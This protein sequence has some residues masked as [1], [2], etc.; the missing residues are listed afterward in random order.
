MGLI[1]LLLALSVV[2][3][4]VGGVGGSVLVGGDVAVQGFFVISGFYMALVLTEKYARIDDVG[5]RFKT[6]YTARLMRLYPVYAVVVVLTF[7]VDAGVRRQWEHLLQVRGGIYGMT[8]LVLLVATNLFIVGQDVVVFI[9]A[10]AHGGLFVAHSLATNR[11]PLWPYLLIPPAWSLSLELVFYSLAPSLVRR[12]VRVLCGIA[13]VSLGCRFAVSYAG[14][15]V[16]PWTYRFFPSELAFFLAGILAY[17]FHRWYRARPDRRAGVLA[18]VAVI[19]A[20]GAYSYVDVPGKQDLFF[21]LL[22]IAVPVVFE[23]TKRSRLDRFIGDLSYPLYICHWTVISIVTVHS[24]HAALER[25]ALSVLAAGAL[26][27][28]V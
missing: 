16:D 2:L 7:A 18:L 19:A 15:N 10:H 5:R 20:A 22:A 25:S 3:A 21:V 1:R 12:G 8:G 13:L 23:L 28:V 27:L 9:G 14:L 17:R 4:H 6:F 26:L 11:F 24:P